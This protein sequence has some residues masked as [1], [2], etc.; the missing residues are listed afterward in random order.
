[1]SRYHDWMWSEG[2]KCEACPQRNNPRRKTCANCKAYRVD[3]VNPK[4][5]PCLG[6]GDTCSSQLE[7]IYS[8]K[9]KPWPYCSGCDPG[10]CEGESFCN[11]TKCRVRKSGAA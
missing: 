4:P 5:D 1:M 9:A 11:C 10:L 2:W 7:F 6:C 8:N 3:N